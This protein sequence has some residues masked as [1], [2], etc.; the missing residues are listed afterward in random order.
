MKKTLFLKTVAL[1]CIITTMAACKKD[2]PDPESEPQ[3]TFVGT[4][5]KI[6]YEEYY[7]SVWNTYPLED[8]E[9]DDKII[10]TATTFTLDF[11]SN[12]NGEINTNGTYT[13]DAATKKIALTS[14]N[15][16]ET[17]SYT[18]LFTDTELVMVDAVADDI[19]ITYKK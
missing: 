5:T 3:K 11:G 17:R 18:V 4:W 16:G 9:K 6:K 7:K 15:W 2:T 14:P 12:K 19:R 10:F 13:Y 1:L 8:S